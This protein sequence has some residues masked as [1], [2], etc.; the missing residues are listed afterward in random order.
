M[1]YLQGRCI[2][3]P[4]WALLILAFILTLW[5]SAAG[6]IPAFARKYKFSCTTCHAPVPRLKPFG[7]DFAGNAFQLDEKEEPKRYFHETGDEHLTLMR[8]LPLAVRFDAFVGHTHF[9]GGNMSMTDLKVPYGLKMMSGGNLSRHIGYYFYFYMSEQGE[10]AGIEDA[11]IHFND[12][13]G[14]DLD[15]MVGQFQVSDPLFKREL[16]LTYQDYLIYK[17]RVGE[18][19]TNLAYDRGIMILYGAPTGTDVV[20][21][22]VNGNGKDEEGE[23]GFDNEQ[24]KNVFLRLSHS[25][26]PVRVGGFGYLCNSKKL[27]AGNLENQH[28]YWGVDGTVDFG[29]TVQINGQYL[30]RRDD[31]PFWETG[32]VEE[33]RVKGGLAELVWAPRGVDGRSYVTLLAN[34]IDSDKGLY[35]CRAVT[36]SYSY[37][38]RRNMRL[39]AEVTY[40]DEWEQYDFITGLVSAF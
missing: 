6:A 4:V 11:Y 26:G 22:I 27:G 36:L 37:L 2:R 20:L 18:S 35:D 8:D 19:P 28:Y 3:N 13:G 21:E 32:P 33:Y 16:R 14:K 38:L 23:T 29:K 9:S 12:L 1:P 25:C 15:V 10:V 31:N 34:I 5:P 24:W 39:L 17:L 40:E 30:E 7:E